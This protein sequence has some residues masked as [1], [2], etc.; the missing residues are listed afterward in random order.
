MEHRTFNKL[1]SYLRG[2]LISKL[3]GAFL[4]VIMIGALVIYILTTQ[5]TQTA[6]RIYTTQ[7]S[8]LWAER[9]APDFASYYSQANTW[10]GVEGYIQANLVSNDIPGMMGM[11][12]GRAG[13]GRGAGSS[14]MGW[15]GG[16]DQRLILADAQGKVIADTEQSLLGSQL[17]ADEIAS[18]APVN[19]QNQ[20]VGTLVVVPVSLQTTTNP[21]SI[22]LASV[23][24]SI[25]I[26][27]LV[28]GAIS[29]ALV[30]FFS[31]QITAPIRQMQKAA[32]AIA[33]GD[34]N[35]R[36]PVRSNDELGSLAETFNQMA[37]S[38]ASAE[39]LRQ[40]LLADVAHELRTPLA[41][42]QANT[43]G[44]QDGVLPLD[45]EQINTIHAETLL[46]GRLINDL[47]LISLA[48]SGELRLERRPVDIG[49]LLQNAKD[50][51]APQC[52]QKKIAL[53]L[54]IEE[55]L[56]TVWADVDRINQVLNNLI[57][58]ALRYTSEGGN[59][60]LHAGLASGGA[61]LI[62]VS[63]TD[64]GSGIAK[65]DLPWIFDRFYRADKSRTRV[66]GGTGL[67]LAIVKQLI[68]AHGGHVEAVSP[69]SASTGDA[70]Q[71]GTGT[72]IAFSLPAVEAKA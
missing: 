66:S 29:L 68:E 12:S 24:R 1:P 64:S 8:Q 19:V 30:L 50:R 61:N 49:P 17:S 21:A 7:N 37:S 6:F 62:Q 54:S 22:F 33:H 16:A 41:V 46:L 15:M 52:A 59:I 45:I 25:V 48:E 10:Q 13:L 5:A 39:T 71:Q 32:G 60:L 42:I 31:L 63:V 56:P 55:Y 3:I 70:N 4:L 47:R 72:R 11:G 58:N 27:V 36:V 40:K 23:N 38:L 69:V 67:G 9:L 26:S 57:S 20:T 28:A 2:S 43:E 44:I 35:Q 14:G 34:L 65:E 53:G 18:G 51:F